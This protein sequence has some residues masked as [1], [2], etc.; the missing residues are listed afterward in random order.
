MLK[1]KTTFGAPQGRRVGW[2]NAK[3]QVRVIE[4]GGNVLHNIPVP[5]L[6][7]P[8]PQWED[9]LQK[10]W[11]MATNGTYRS[12]AFQPFPL[13][14]RS[15]FFSSFS[16]LPSSNQLH[17]SLTLPP[18]ATVSLCRLVAPSPPALPITRRTF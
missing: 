8:V 2:K 11:K 18:N 6:M 10:V 1:L 12:N 3:E 4:G 9:W 14:S 7:V 16:P 5:D 13:E 17:C 15:L